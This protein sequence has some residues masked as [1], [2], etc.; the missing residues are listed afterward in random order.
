MGANGETCIAMVSNSVV[1]GKQAENHTHGEAVGS[2]SRY[3]GN[4]SASIFWSNRDCWWQRSLPYA[5]G[6]WL[7]YRYEWGNQSNKRKIIFVKKPLRII[8]PLDPMEGLHYKKP[9]CDYDSDDNLDC[10]YKILVR[11]QGWV[12]P[13]VN[14]WIT[15]DR[16]SS[17]TLNS[18]EEI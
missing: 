16:K 17:C 15:W 6:N 7:A 18:Y 10:I 8:I 1:N 13:T 14:G 4:E 11:D 5:L 2:D 3:W 12:N 9:V